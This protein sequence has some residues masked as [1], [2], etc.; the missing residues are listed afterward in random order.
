MHMEH[1]NALLI[2]I[3]R[4][5]CTVNYRLQGFKSIAHATDKIP[6]IFLL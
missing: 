5:R 4:K 1:Q 2:L 3:Y 6:V